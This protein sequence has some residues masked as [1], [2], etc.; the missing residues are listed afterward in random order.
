MLFKNYTICLKY[1]SL[2]DK[3]KM[4]ILKNAHNDVNRNHIMK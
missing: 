2:Y 3:I 1:E 4:K